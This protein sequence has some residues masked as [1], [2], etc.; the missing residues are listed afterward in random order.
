MLNMKT[1]T[2][3][4]LRTLLF[5]LVMIM[6]MTETPAQ[7][8]MTMPALQNVTEPSE[9][10]QLRQQFALRALTSARM[11]ADQYTKALAALEEQSGL[12]GDYE[13]ALAAQQR[14]QQ[15]A[16]WYATSAME[17]SE[18]IVLK[19]ADAKTTGPVAYER[20]ENV[21]EGWRTSGSTASW[22]ITKINPGTFTVTMTYGATSMVEGLN[23]P[24]GFG[25]PEGMPAQGGEI[26][27][28]EI[29]SLGGADAEK[30]TAQVKPTGSWTTF[31]TITLGDLKLARTSARLTLKVSRLRGTSGLMHLRE[32]RL[33]PARPTAVKVDETAA[34]EYAGERQAHL[35]HLTE[36]GQPVVDAYLARLQSISD[37]L[38]EKKDD[39]GVQALL[40]ESRRVQQS[41][42][43][44]GKEMQ[45]GAGTAIIRPDG[46]EEI[47][48]VRY[49]PDPTNTG[50]RFLVATKNQIISVRLMSVSCP[51]PR[52]EDEE[53]HKYHSTYFGITMDDSVAVGRQAQEFTDTYLKDKPLRILTRWMRDKSGSIL[54]I[55]QPGEVGDFSGILVDNGLAAITSPRAKHNAG[56]RMEEAMLA[57]LKERETAAKSKALPP[58]AWS[59]L[60]VIPKP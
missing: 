38:A 60:P 39:D 9:L 24:F 35:G 43:L 23:G 34:K 42:H 36:L 4:L 15:L 8:P 18:S 48:D 55:V 21:L 27:F 53:S 11:L 47:Q 50:D 41:L 19:P 44:L 54:A 13:I 22:D 31:E 51:T 37:E 20:K 45:P 32:I 14:R 28:S 7:A 46:L 6:P 49:V 3:T 12:S 2:I 10:T 29:T 17:N 56:K 59:F 33:T 1:S 5:C 40:N 52:A 57:S 58:G 16:S 30:L 25:P 26:E